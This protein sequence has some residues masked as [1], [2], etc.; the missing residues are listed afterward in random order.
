MGAP[1]WQVAYH[2]VAIRSSNDTASKELGFKSKGTTVRGSREGDWLRLSDEL[3][4][5]RIVDR[6]GTQLLVQQAPSWQVAYHEVAI[7]SSNDT[8]SKELGFKSKGTTVRGSRE[9][10][11][12]R[13][14]DELGYMRI[15]DRDGTQLL[16]QQ[17]TMPSITA[18][19]GAKSTLQ[20]CSSRVSKLR[21]S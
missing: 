19:S 8:A 2:E 20:T 10:D 6:D 15:V 5:M 4:Y 1:S 3:G 16:V 9:G 14:S 18:T 21:V 13:L 12:L 17:A 11:W 7:R